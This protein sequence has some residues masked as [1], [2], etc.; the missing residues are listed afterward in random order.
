M[1]VLEYRKAAKAYAKQ[2]ADMIDLA[3]GDV[4]EVYSPLTKGW[5]KGINL[6][7]KLKGWFPYAYTQPTQNPNAAH[8]TTSP[9]PSIP[10]TPQSAK[11][12][13]ASPQKPVKPTPQAQIAKAA[14]EEEDSY[15]Y[16][17]DDEEKQPVKQPAKQAAKPSVNTSDQLKAYA[18]KISEMEN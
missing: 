16:S 18:K 13:L 5:A 3:V 10:A 1:T 14:K 17:D 7:T 15:Y 11:T 9:A 6:R 4:V 8:V 2:R 12:E